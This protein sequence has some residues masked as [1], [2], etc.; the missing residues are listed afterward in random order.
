M[1]VTLL[2]TSFEALKPQ[3]PRLVDRFYAILFERYPR[4]KPMFANVDM[5]TLKN[6]LIQALALLV[7]NLERA[8]ILKSYLNGLGA[9]HVRYGVRDE[10]YDAV[11]QSLLS[12]MG[13]V[14]GPLWTDELR[15]EWAATYGVV[16]SLMKQGAAAP[17]G[18]GV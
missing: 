8:D 12:A 10:H 17:A 15:N 5:S 4:V 11:G 7:A 2:R 6:R 18:V 9:K 14:A 1:N 13:E 16:A 3:A